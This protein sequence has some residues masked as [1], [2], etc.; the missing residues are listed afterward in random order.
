M[1]VRLQK[2]Q[3]AFIG[4]VLLLVATGYMNYRFNALQGEGQPVAVQGETNA[5]ATPGTTPSTT[6]EET[7]QTNANAGL[8][9]YTTFRTERTTT[10]EKELSYLNEIIKDE[11]ADAETIQKAQEQKLALVEAMET[12]TTVEGLIK[13]KGFSEC[14]VTIKEGSVNVVVEN[15]KALTSAQAAQIMEIVRSET[16]EDS[17][18]IKIMPRN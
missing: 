14:V 15:E 3:W 11:K 13:A 12:E 2:K 8:Q 16:G 5:T 1:K 17:E 10:R 18:N 4:L 6:G 7:Q 9:Y